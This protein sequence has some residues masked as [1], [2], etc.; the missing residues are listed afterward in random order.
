MRE[1]EKRPHLCPKCG[2]ILE[3][4]TGYVG[5]EVLVCPDEDCD[6]GVVW[7]DSKDALRRVK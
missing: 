3:S 7:E 6:A 2:E 5:E 4:S 1:N